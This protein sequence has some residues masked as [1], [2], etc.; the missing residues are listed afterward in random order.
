MQS[1]RVD[2]AHR[3]VNHMQI[4]FRRPNDRPNIHKFCSQPV[5]SARDFRVN[6]F[7]W[8]DGYYYDWFCFLISTLI[9]IEMCRNWFKNKSKINVNNKPPY[10][11]QLT[12]YPSGQ[13]HHRRRR[14]RRCFVKWKLHV[15]NWI[16]MFSGSRRDRALTEHS[17]FVVSLLPQNSDG[18]HDGDWLIY[19]TWTWTWSI[20]A[21]KVTIVKSLTWH[22]NGVCFRAIISGLLD[23]WNWMLGSG[24]VCKWDFGVINKY[25]EI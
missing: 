11:T 13:N 7:F 12:A 2:H 9:I 1:G 21:Q 20:L 22:V 15:S 14:R 17:F 18:T 3:G 10:P 6:D 23:W 19:W 4:S 24:S 5:Q 16:M 8:L 25:L